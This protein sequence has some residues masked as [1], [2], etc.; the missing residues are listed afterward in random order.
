MKS[1][2][3]GGERCKNNHDLTLL[4]LLRRLI[5]INPVDWA[6]G[7]SF[8]K[9]VL[10]IIRSAPRF[11][12][13]WCQPPIRFCHRTVRTHN[14]NCLI[15]DKPEKAACRPA[16]S[17]APSL[18]PPGQP[19]RISMQK[20]SA[21]FRNLA[22]SPEFCQVDFGFLPIMS[23]PGL[24]VP[25]HSFKCNKPRGK[26]THPGNP[27]LSRVF[28]IWQIAGID[29]RAEEFARVALLCTLILR[30]T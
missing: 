4:G 25:L 5:R 13:S 6:L 19:L 22:F 20:K 27:E 23:P 11:C 16:H 18:Y 9:S 28:L 7:K 1:K 15:E 2:N 3:A 14:A 26:S 29:P 30:H 8:R 17:L 24:R 21:G 10:T 12:H